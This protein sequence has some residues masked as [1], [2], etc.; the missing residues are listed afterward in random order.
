MEGFARVT[1][2][3]DT[4]YENFGILGESPAEVLPALANPSNRFFGVGAPRAGW[5]G[6]RFSF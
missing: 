5:V 1:N 6:L 2:L 3:F 4:D